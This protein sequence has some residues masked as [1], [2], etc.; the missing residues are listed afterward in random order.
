MEKSR[1]SGRWTEG[2][3]RGFISTSLRR[4]FQRWQP[5]YDTLDAAKVGVQRSK[6]TG[7]NAMH[8][9]CASC[10]KVFPRK[11]VQVDHI[12]A[13]G[14][15]DT[16]DKFIERLFCESINL[17]V[18]CIKCHEKKTKNDNQENRKRRGS[19]RNDRGVSPL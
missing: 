7:R 1:N 18:L 3:F 17:Q 14:T 16:W 15:C 8:Y 2:R 5:K 10:P 13:I 12:T 4:A 11:Q 6:K 9:Q 19:R